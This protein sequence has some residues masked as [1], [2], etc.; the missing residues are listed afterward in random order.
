MT[1]SPWGSG[2]GGPWGSGGAGPL[3]VPCVFGGPIYQIPFGTI[4]GTADIN[5]FSGTPTAGPIVLDFQ[6]PGL[7]FF[8]PALFNLYINNEID[9]DYF[10]VTTIAADIYQQ[11]IQEN[12]RVFMFGPNSPSRTNDA[13]YRTQPGE[14][15][16]TG[17][18]VQTIPPGPTTQIRVM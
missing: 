8:S 16:I 3:P 6:S 18:M 14:Y 13:L 1:T 4:F 10:D 2:W 5:R 11:P 7:I 9:V 17:E 12:N 15:T